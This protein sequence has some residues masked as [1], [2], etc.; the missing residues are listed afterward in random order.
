MR[1]SI[2]KY[3]VKG[4]YF[5]EKWGLRLMWGNIVFMIF[6]VVMLW[7]KIEIDQRVYG[8]LMN[9]PDYQEAIKAKVLKDVPGHFNGP[10]HMDQPT[11]VS[12]ESGTT[13]NK[14]IGTPKPEQMHH[15]ILK[16]TH[17]D[18]AGR[19][20]LIEFIDLTTHDTITEIP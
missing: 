7:N 4:A 1:Y 20:T 14:A 12:D 17:F 6:S 16:R 10:M 3:F 8:Q 2:I 15:T 13:P 9:S 11:P 5:C 18:S 19:P